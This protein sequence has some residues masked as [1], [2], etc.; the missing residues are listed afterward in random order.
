MLI[1]GTATG[2]FRTPRLRLGKQVDAGDLDD[3]HPR[4]FLVV[5]IVEVWV[6]ASPQLGL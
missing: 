3:G 6:G 2:A 4:G 5:A 1:R